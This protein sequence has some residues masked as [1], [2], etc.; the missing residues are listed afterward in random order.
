M[1]GT[2]ENNQVN[3]DIDGAH[4][5][6]DQTSH[7]TETAEGTGQE[8]ADANDAAGGGA[9]GARAEGRELLTAR[10]WGGPGR[11]PERD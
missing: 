11:R 2:N 10:R 3:E 7:A 6:G 5:A 4:P 1:H 8:V 9:E